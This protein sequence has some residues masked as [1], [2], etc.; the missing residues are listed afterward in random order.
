[1]SHP[2]K[3]ALIA[4][5]KSLGY[6]VDLHFV[7]TADPSINVL[8]VEDR[9][10][11]G[12][13]GVDANK[14]VARYYRS[15]SLLPAAAELADATFVYDNSAKSS[16]GRAQMVARVI[17]GQVEVAPN[18]PDYYQKCFIEPFTKGR[19]AE[20]E[21][22]RKALPAGHSMHRADLVKGQTSGAIIEVGNHFLVQQ[23]RAAVFVH[24]RAVLA[25][26]GIK[27]LPRQSP[28]ISY[29]QGDAKAIERAVQRE[30]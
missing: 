2:S 16:E 25:A 23:H 6:Q 26:C 15:L 14:I 11:K 29:R 13:H 28:T 30:R 12:G 22:I 17:D 1:M 24:D 10:A 18:P 5:A 21:A 19:P 20:L 3:V 4:H 7:S 8:R 27:L 9:V